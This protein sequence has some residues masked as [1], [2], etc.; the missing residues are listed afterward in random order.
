LLILGLTFCRRV[1]E[2]EEDAEEVGYSREFDKK[3][4]IMFSLSFALIEV[5]IGAVSAVTGALSIP[6]MLGAGL[7]V[8]LA[9][10]IIGL[11]V[12]FFWNRREK[13]KLTSVD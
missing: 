7:I 4:F 2:A 11:I 8:D 10:L 6:P 3:S 13:A 9:V 1:V 12:A 5:I